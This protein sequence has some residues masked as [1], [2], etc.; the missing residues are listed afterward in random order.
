[1]PEPTFLGK[2]P[3]FYGAPAMINAVLG[4]DCAS[5]GCTVLAGDGTTTSVELTAD[6]T[7]DLTTTEPLRVA[8]VSPDGE[9]W[10]VNLPPVDEGDQYGCSGIYELD[11][12]RVLARTCDTTFGS[13][14]PD[15]TRV[16]GAR[17]DNQMWDSVEVVEWGEGAEPVL[18]FQAERGQVVKDWGWAD[19]DHLLVVVTELDAPSDSSLLRVP[20]DGSQPEV[21]AGPVRGA[22]VEDPSVFVISD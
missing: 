8:D 2:V 1:V 17:G 9:R 16:T 12:E 14:S 19:S 7:R 5:G 15:G 10:A 4:S 13:F 6:G 11:P 3:K 21:V 18:S 22:G 20:V